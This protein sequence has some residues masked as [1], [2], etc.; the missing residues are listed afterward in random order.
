[1]ATIEKRGKS[2]RIT[3]SCGYDV[4][5]TQERPRMTWR[6]DPGMTDRQIEK[7]LNRR[8]VLFEEECKQGFTEKSVKFE[9][10]T[11]Q[12]Y[13]IDYVPENLRIRTITEYHRYEKRTYQFIGYLRMDKIT[14]TQIQKFVRWLLKGDKSYK[15][16]SKKSAKNYLSFVSSVF[17]YA[18]QMRAAKNNPCHS[19]KIKIGE[20]EERDCYTLEE[21]QHFLDLLLKELLCYQ[22][23]FTLAIYGGY[24]RGELCGLEWKDIDFDTG[25]VSIR[26]TSE[27]TKDQGTFTDTTKTKKSQRSLKMP[28]EVIEILRKYHAKQSQ[29]RLKAGDRWGNSDRLF[30]GWNGKPINPNSPYKWMR[31]FCERNGLRHPKGALHSLRHLNASLLI[32]SGADAKTVSAALGHSQVSTTLNI[33]THTFERVQ[34]AASEAVAAKLPLK[35]HA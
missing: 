20:K 22:A 7:E 17:E 14:P 23:F 16:L 29:D 9:E 33:Y 15:P 26:R 5:G 12:R 27:Y 11:R 19:V 30:V 35:S 4:D 2:Y 28:D 31:R 24:R 18:I 3:A 8:A 34:A 21:A 13:F 32:T 6:P 25:V 1:M 10:F